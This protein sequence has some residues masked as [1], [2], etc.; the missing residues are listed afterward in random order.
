MLATPL[1]EPT[2]QLLGSRTAGVSHP[3][4]LARAERAGRRTWRVGAVEAAQESV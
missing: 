3:G 4:T 1:P 2:T